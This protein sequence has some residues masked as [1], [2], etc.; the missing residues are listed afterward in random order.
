MIFRVKIEH[1]PLNFISEVVNVANTI[2]PIKMDDELVSS[3]R[4]ICAKSGVELEDLVTDYLDFVTTLEDSVVDRVKEI[5][6][7]DK[8]SEWLAK[9]YLVVRA[10]QLNGL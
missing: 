6:N 3:A 4:E 2:L 5:P 1:Q 10:N 9:H 8:K 7:E